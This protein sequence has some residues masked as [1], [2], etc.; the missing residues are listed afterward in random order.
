MAYAVFWV[1]LCWRGRFVAVALLVVGAACMVAEV[2]AGVP[3]VVAE[4]CPPNQRR[5]L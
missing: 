2:V 3:G 1:D 4:A 5:T